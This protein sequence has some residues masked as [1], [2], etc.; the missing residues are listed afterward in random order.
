[1]IRLILEK[2]ALKLKNFKWILNAASA[3]MKGFTKA[4]NSHMNA[5]LKDAA[6]SIK[7]YV[8]NCLPQ[9]IS[10]TC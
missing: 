2:S 7:K 8:K 3:V 6:N 5:F 9:R 1:M 10:E 4:I